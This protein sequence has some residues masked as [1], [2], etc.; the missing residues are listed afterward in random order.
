MFGR[1]WR[2]VMGDIRPAPGSRMA[3]SVDERLSEPVRSERPQLMEPCSVW[4]DCLLTAA[5]SPRLAP[6]L[7]HAVPKEDAELEGQS[8]AAGGSAGGGLGGT[9]AQLQSD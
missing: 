9:G 4:D 8:V 2:G 6:R 3:K 5:A 7:W 1:F